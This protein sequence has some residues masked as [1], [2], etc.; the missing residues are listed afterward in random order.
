MCP[1]I[2]ADEV[3][4]LRIACQGCGRLFDVEVHSDPYLRKRL[5]DS[6]T[7]IYYSD[8]PNVGCCPAGPTMSSISLHVIQFWKKEEA[9]RWSRRHEHENIP[10]E[11]L[12]EY[13]DRTELAGDEI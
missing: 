1:D 4:L 3:V 8:P 13:F 10:I 11:S 5:S 12:G 9:N 7:E 6:P 2:Y